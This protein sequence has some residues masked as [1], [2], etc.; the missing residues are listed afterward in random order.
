MTMTLTSTTLYRIDAVEDF[1]QIDVDQDIQVT[2]THAKAEP[3][4]PPN[5]KEPI[6]EPQ[7]TGAETKTTTFNVRVPGN[8]ND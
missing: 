2:S 7:I 3:E 4:K 5:P 6:K 1:S 8:A